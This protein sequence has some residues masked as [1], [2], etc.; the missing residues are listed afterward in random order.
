MQPTMMPVT[1]MNASRV[2]RLERRC[3]GISPAMPLSVL[4][5]APDTTKMPPHCLEDSTRRVRAS[6]SSGRAS[7]HAGAWL[8]RVAPG[9]HPDDWTLPLGSS[10]YP[11]LAAAILRGM[12]AEFLKSHFHIDL[13]LCMRFDCILDCLPIEEMHTVTP[14][15]SP[16]SLDWLPRSPCSIHDETTTLCLGL[17][18][19]FVR[20]SRDHRHGYFRN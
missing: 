8:S 2:T 5:P 1:T 12:A 7:W 13:A 16:V 15:E 10:A 19:P 9:E 20:V 18:S 14:Q 6:I 17:G 11:L 3:A 4:I